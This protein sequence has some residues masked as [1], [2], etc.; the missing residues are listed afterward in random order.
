MLTSTSIFFLNKYEKNVKERLVAT[1]DLPYK[2]IVP[3]KAYV[4]KGWG[5]CNSEISRR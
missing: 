2:Q 3:T 5:T 1:Q 4:V